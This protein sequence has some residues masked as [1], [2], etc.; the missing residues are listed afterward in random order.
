[1]LCFCS[2]LHLVVPITDNR[3]EPGEI[4]SELIPKKTFSFVKAALF[5]VAL[6]FTASAIPLMAEVAV[7]GT[8]QA[9]AD[10]AAAKPNDGITPGSIDPTKTT[11]G[12][13]SETS[14][15]SKGNVVQVKDFVPGTQ[16]VKKITV[17]NWYYANQNQGSVTTYTLQGNGDVKTTIK[18]YSQGGKELSSESWITAPGGLVSNSNSAMYPNGCINQDPKLDKIR[19][20]NEKTSM[21]SGDDETASAMGDVGLTPSSG[22]YVEVY[23]GLNLYQNYGG[24]KAY[25]TEDGVRDTIDG[26]MKKFLGGTGG[27]NVGY[28]F[29][30]INT[31]LLMVQPA[32]RGDIS[33]LGTSSTILYEGETNH[34]NLNTVPI[35]VNGLLFFPTGSQFTP[36][37]GVGVGMDI[38]QGTAR[39]E[40]PGG[41][42]RLGSAS[43]VAPALEQIIGLNVTLDKQWALF[44][45]WK[46]NEGFAPRLQINNAAG[47]GFD[48]TQKNDV[49]TQ[50]SLNFGIKYG[51]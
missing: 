30:P 8:P 48:F 16:I 29:Q 7:T 23:G 43:A 51:F 41:D 21:S 40:G 6:I 17:Y 1:L 46:F 32:I 24:A 11:T 13:D 37:V 35:M 15:D 4:V 5:S 42:L 38:Y 39:W 25:T 12:K 20:H 45:E 18:T 34:Y 26:P 10:G 47:E 31:G 9:S 19:S 27:F 44:G 49:L 14:K 22:Y 3:L 33:W 36:Y 2:H 28:D 50:G